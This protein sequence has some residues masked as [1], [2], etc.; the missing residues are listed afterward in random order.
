[1]L[2]AIWDRHALG[3]QPWLRAFMRRSN[4]VAGALFILLGAGFV[5]SQGGLLLSA[6]YDDLGL[7][8]LGFRLEDWLANT[9]Q[10]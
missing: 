3:K 1:V 5:V 2:A 6:T 10:L 4:V 7:T 8:A 9:L